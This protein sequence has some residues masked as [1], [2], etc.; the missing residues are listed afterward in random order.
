MLKGSS[1]ILLILHLL[2]EHQI[3]PWAATVPTEANTDGT[4]TSYCI[5]LGNGIYQNASGQ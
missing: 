1:W 3:F 2:N 5:L 4:K